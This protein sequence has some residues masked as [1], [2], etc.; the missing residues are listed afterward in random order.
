L[1]WI[2]GVWQCAGLKKHP[3]R[4][5]WIGT[6]NAITRRCSFQCA[7]IKACT[8]LLSFLNF[9][10]PLTNAG[11]FMEA[12][13]DAERLN[14]D[15]QQQKQELQRDV[16]QIKIAGRNVVKSLEG[17]FEYNPLVITGVSLL[18]GFALGC[19][20]GAIIKAARPALEAGRPA[21][22]AAIGPVVKAALIAAAAQAAK[23]VVGGPGAE[24]SPQPSPTTPIPS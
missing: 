4:L 13:Q 20:S 3:P 24:N 8:L 17:F 18:A 1:R 11:P 14:S 15:L 10:D 9:A 22:R 12:T 21:V 6:V 2:F 7:R 19:R 5:I 16:R 23:S